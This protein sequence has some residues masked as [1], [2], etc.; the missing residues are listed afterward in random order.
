MKEQEKRLS[1][2]LS[3][4]SKELTTALS[5]EHLGLFAEEE[6]VK[7]FL[8]DMTDQQTK[9]AQIRANSAANIEDQLIPILKELLGEIKKK[10]SDTDGKW[11][12]LDKELSSDLETYI[13]LAANVRTSLMRQQWKGE[14]SEVPEVGKD[15]PRDPWIAN[16]ALQRHIAYCNSKQQE[17]RDKIIAQQE[18][19]AAFEAVVVQNIKVSMST[20]Y[21]WRSSN[22]TQ[23]VDQ[24]KAM[25][26][27]LNQMDPERD[28]GLF[29]AGNEKRFLTP[30]PLVK[31]SDLTY[32]G[33]DDP[34]LTI[35]KQGK[36]LRKEGVFKRA[37]KPSVGVLT[38]SGFLHTL[39]EL[40]PGE[41]FYQSPEISIDL[42]ECTLAPLM[43]NEKE[44]E[45]LALLGKGGG[46]FG[47]DS[48]HKFRGVT[49]AD[50][51]EWWGAINDLM[52]AHEGKRA[53]MSKVTADSESAKKVEAAPVQTTQSKLKESPPTKVQTAPNTP[54]PSL[55]Q[56]KPD[57]PV[58]EGPKP[59]PVEVQ[60]FSTDSA[61]G[62][63]PVPQTYNSSPE[64]V[65]DH[66]GFYNTSANSGGIN[67]DLYYTP[68]VDN[69]MAH[70]S[71]AER[72]EQA[73]NSRKPPTDL[74]EIP[75]PE[76]K[77]A[78][79]FEFKAEADPFAI[80]PSN[81]WDTFD[82]GGGGWS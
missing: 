13:R 32:D 12:Q 60:A 11:T 2:S 27:Q 14:N 70:L 9:R 57:L 42:A 28:W 51:A 46:M 58:K 78:D 75:V 68:P 23:Q 48:K 74:E 82:A 15:T 22:F 54:K 6:S 16:Q 41:Q 49:M 72:M 79:T 34:G 21:E 43:M 4:T 76:F 19:F 31:L 10:A 29:A 69:S 64:V 50:S 37:Y 30:C 18:D 80:K 77:P 66:S 3:K 35:V 8:Q 40:G 1:E 5:S 38:H 20:F 39:P 53:T 52:K 36:L 67:H 26:T 33:H 63:S 73:Y 25:Q 81:P 71:I 24:I 65:S 47:R 59:V 17:Y 45:E 7:S 55:P 61:F 62:A 44:P 56:R